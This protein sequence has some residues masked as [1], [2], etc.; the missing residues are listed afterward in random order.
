MKKKNWI[1]IVVLCLCLALFAAYWVYNRMITDTTAPAITVEQPEQILEVSVEDPPSVLLAGITARDNRDGDVTASLVVE[2]MGSINDDGTLEIT[3][4]AFDKSGNVAKVR[5][6][7]RYTDYVGPRFTLTAPLVYTFGS[8]FDVLNAISA[9]DPF[10]GNIDHRIK[11]LLLDES[12]LS[13]QGTHTV[14]FSV[15]NSLADTEVLELPVEVIQ[16]GRHTGQLKL[17]EYLVYLPIGQTFDPQ[18]YLYTYV[19]RGN[20][21]SLT[22]RLPQGITYQTEGTVDTTVPGIYPVAYT[23]KYT[24]GDY[25]STAYSKLFVVVEG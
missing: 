14:R 3:C 1:Y 6:S 21:I 20:T 18:D 13:E 15:T 4:A 17:S 10:D 8:Q 19:D 25:S 16:G 12:F 23:V 5:R 7:V 24:Q 2:R 22:L 9:S 11:L